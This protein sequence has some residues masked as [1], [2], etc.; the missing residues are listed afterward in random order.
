ALGVL[1]PCGLRAAGRRNPILG[2]HARHVVLFEGHATSFQVGDFALDIVNLPESLACPGRSGIWCRIQETCGMVAELVD[3]PTGLLSP[4]P[5][6]ELA[7]VEVAGTAH[8]LRWDVGEH[9]RILEHGCL[10]VV[11]PSR[12]ARISPAVF[13]V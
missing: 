1:E 2:L 13:L 6:A 9:R 11:R 8:V 7:L 12:K 4:G 10:L 5:E 3:D